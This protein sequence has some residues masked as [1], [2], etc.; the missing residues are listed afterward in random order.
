MFKRRVIPVLFLKDGWMVRSQNFKLHQYMGDPV[1][2]VDRMVEWDVDELIVLDIGAEDSVFDHHRT[3]YRNKPVTTV[4]EFIER[5]GVQCSIPLT[6]GGRIRSY[7][8][9]A[10][11]ISNGADRIAVNSMLADDPATVTRAARDFG[12]QAVV[13]SVDYRMIDGRAVAFTGRGK[14]S[15][16][17]DVLDWSRR[18]E[19][20][21]AGEI[22]LNAMDRDGMAQGFDIETVAAVADAL[23]IPVIACGGAGKNEHFLEALTQTRAAAVAAGNIFHFKE[24]AY[25]AAKAFLKAELQEIR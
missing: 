7:D 12:A 22:L 13:A 25:P 1:A 10:V 20:L 24:N 2:H 18:A 16:E 23:S 11:R 17:A 14:V 19:D 5:A 15:T 4:L 9:I 3:D 21:G 6:F 8:D